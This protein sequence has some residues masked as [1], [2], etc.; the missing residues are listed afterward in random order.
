MG[1]LDTPHPQ[2]WTSEVQTI[3][4]D[5]IIEILS[6]L[7]HNGIRFAFLLR[8]TT[9]PSFLSFKHLAKL[10]V[11]FASTAAFYPLEIDPS[12]CSDILVNCLPRVS[13]PHSFFGHKDINL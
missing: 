4:G 1:D 6:K 12:I 10:P 5:P 9:N 2:D 3:V 11:K 8:M 7:S 13:F